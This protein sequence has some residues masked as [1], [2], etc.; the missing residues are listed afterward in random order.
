MKDVSRHNKMRKTSA[1]PG[2]TID[3]RK[4]ES[5]RLISL[6]AM[7]T[8]AIAMPQTS[9]ADIIFTDLSANPISIFGTNGSTFLINNLPGTAQLGFCGHTIVSPPMTLATHLIQAS[10]K[11]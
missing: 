10:Q 2:S 8:G 11:F 6:L 9:N 4:A 3:N 1:K 5:T 7:A